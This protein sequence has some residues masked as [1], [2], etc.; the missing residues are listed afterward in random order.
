MTFAFHR[1]YENILCAQH[2]KL[3]KGPAVIS[4][5]LQSTDIM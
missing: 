5:S 2:Y 3:A 1:N 4:L